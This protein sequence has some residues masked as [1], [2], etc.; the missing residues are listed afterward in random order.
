MLYRCFF[1]SSQ[2]FFFFFFSYYA[3]NNYNYAVNTYVICEKQILSEKIVR[4]KINF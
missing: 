4:N 2:V 3:V 1:P